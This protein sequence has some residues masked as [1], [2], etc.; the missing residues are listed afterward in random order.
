MTGAAEEI[1]RGELCPDLARA[2]EE[3]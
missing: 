3:L 1:Y 2:L